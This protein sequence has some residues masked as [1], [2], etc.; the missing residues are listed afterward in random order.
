MRHPIRK[1]HSIFLRLFRI[2]VIAG[3]VL[4]TMLILLHMAFNKKTSNEN[5][6]KF[7]VP[8]FKG[9]IYELGDPPDYHAAMNLKQKYKIDILYK[10]EKSFWTTSAN[11]FPDAR[12]ADSVT[13]H[14]M[15]K[16]RPTH[17]FFI[18]IDGHNGIFWIR[19]TVFPF[20]ARFGL[21]IGAI[22]VI[23]VVVFSLIFSSLRRLLHPVKIL[24]NGTNAVAA[25]N[26]DVTVPVHGSD[27]FSVLSDSFNKM[28][29]AIRTMLSQ[30]KQL[31]YDVSHELRSPLTRIKIALEMIP[32]SDSKTDIKH[33][34]R[35]MEIMIDELLETARLEQS[36]AALVVHQRIDIVALLRELTEQ[37]KDVGNSVEI[38]CTLQELILDGNQELLRK[39]FRNII[40]NAI[41]YSASSNFPVQIAISQADK[42]AQIA[43][44]DQGCG[45]DEKSIGQVFE[46]FY[47][48]DFSR[49]RDTGGYGLGLYICKRIIDSH[50]G[51]I[52]VESIA[53]KGTTVLVTIPVHTVL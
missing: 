1:C 19:G 20:S 9:I 37:Y 41:K 47:R 45:I 36:S 46:P 6:S 27:E 32:Q 8:Y 3:V 12:Y 31:L 43:V 2:V 22:T 26:L 35:E 5:L 49:T 14:F 51:R 40:E 53:G 33:D 4:L 30:K 50:K 52:S 23:L 11:I 29:A 28:V 25:G 21:I 44:I 7:V 24:I 13:A 10:G 15:K 17:P 39:A 34:V 38:E 42:F 48:A 16:K 18:R